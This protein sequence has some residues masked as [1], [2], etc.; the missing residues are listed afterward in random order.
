[1]Q[2]LEEC[3]PGRHSGCQPAPTLRSRGLN[4]SSAALWGGDPESAHLSLGPAPATPPLC[5]ASPALSP[6][7]SPA[8]GDKG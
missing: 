5:P 3:G 7:L 2:P 8:A 6:P 1:M 4:S